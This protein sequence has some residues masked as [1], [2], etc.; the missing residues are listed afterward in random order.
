MSTS[1]SAVENSPIPVSSS[2]SFIDD[3]LNSFTTNIIDDSNINDN[4]NDNDINNSI[5]L[6]HGNGGFNE[7]I[8]DNSI[9]NIPNSI[10]DLVKNVNYKNKSTATGLLSINSTPIVVS[11]KGPTSKDIP[12]TKLH[13]I[14]NIDNFNNNILSNY[15]KNLKCD[16]LYDNFSSCKSLT[17]KSLNR[18]SFSDDDDDNINININ[19]IKNNEQ[20]EANLDTNNLN[21]VP[22]FYFNEDFRL[23]DPRIF[24]K[25]INNSNFLSIID[26]NGKSIDHE[27]LQ[28]ELSSYLDIIE[29]HLINEISKSSDNF[30]YALDDLKKITKSSK[31][32][33]NQLQNVDEILSNLNSNKILP[34]KNLIKITQKYKNVLKFNQIL[35]QIKT[36]L[37]QSDLAELYYYKSDYDNC[38][39]TI[40]S[41]FA[42]IKGNIPPH[43]IVDKLILNW[44]FPLSDVNKLPAISPLKRLLSNLISDTGKSYAKLF[45]NLLIDDL[46][47][48]YDNTN[49]Y[50]TLEKLL[51]INNY[52]KKLGSIKIQSFIIE[53]FE[54]KIIEYLKGLTRC[55]E[56]SSAFKLY[57]ERLANELKFIFK[58]N[59]P[60]EN[61]INNNIPSNR[62]DDS[63]S[64]NITN[65]IS[66]A[67]ILS[68]LV[69]NMTPKEFENLL[70]NNYTK[71]YEA[72]Q[73]LLIHKNLLLTNSIDV[74]NNFDPQILKV[75]PDMIMDLDITNS[76][77]S[78]INSIQ[79]RVAKLIK[80]R[81]QQNSFIP[82]N[83]FLRFYKLNQSFITEC[84]IISKGVVN[85][86]ILKDIVNRQLNL[87]I[88]QFHKGS[89]KRCNEII[90][91]EVWKDDG[92]KIESQLI[93]DFIVKAA[94]GTL[95]NSEWTNGLNIEFNDEENNQN[96]ITHSN[97]NNNNE[98][99]ELRK[100]L[101]IHSQNFT[102]PSSVG[103]IL[104]S[105]KA[106]LLLIHHFKNNYISQN[107][108]PELLK[109]INLKIY[110]SVLGAQVT[111]TAGLKHVTTK[112]L[113]L[114]AEVCRFWVSI[115]ADI[116]KICLLE[117]NI[118]S[119]NEY[120]NN[121]HIDKVEQL[122]KDLMKEFEEARTLFGGQIIEIYNKLVAVISDTIKSIVNKVSLKD[123]LLIQMNQIENNDN[124]NSNKIEANN[125]AKVEGEGEIE[126][127]GEGEGETEVQ[128]ETESEN[129][130][131]A[132]LKTELNIG[133]NN[134]KE[135]KKVEEKDMKDKVNLYMEVIVK[136]ILTIARSVQR[137][138]PT[139]EYEGVMQRIL[140]KNEEILTKTYR[141]FVEC[142]TEEDRK[143]VYKQISID[144]EYYED[145]LNINK[146]NVE[147]KGN[148][149][150]RIMASVEMPN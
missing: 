125:E 79:R 65:N 84:E 86:P 132:E 24:N 142:A 57:E 15:I 140:E 150:R 77:N 96:D 48:T 116:E 90:E 31:N 61:N 74:L 89:L 103:S 136:K 87:F 55:G 47:Y 145:K 98:D 75:Q 42:L 29:V 135:N 76:I 45:S 130:T 32:L 117:I 10:Y 52:N 41:V 59:L 1:S 44:Q 9:L 113:A 6:S 26:G 7:N 118:N 144:V 21:N 131:E 62:S 92:L 73:K 94:Q 83:F 104:G 134:D 88:Q 53:D 13:P 60:N 133:N 5:I 123:F 23:D 2:H 120:N 17:T 72:F 19:N 93:V 119:F 34:A 37:N 49:K 51:E 127:E 56:L 146:D 71:F 66:N 126:T 22:K 115:I 122:R 99:D 46:R 27:I 80:I 91:H 12:P 85:E 137:Y 40:D 128:L 95:E 141:H 111:K 25:V 105:I 149:V 63:K 38:L 81:E 30:F 112:H 8:I 101:N 64:T 109:A 139:E 110:Q 11:L 16:D 102:L 68:D 14:N 143:K 124:N 129:K 3:T 33:T 67:L 58:S 106:Y 121:K 70:I 20:N 39:Q 138:L 148:C 4:D 36:I 108:L 43:P 82:L 107:Y 147:D 28:D 18:L 54:L 35:L 78:S 50:K 100:T 114:A 69:K 97:N